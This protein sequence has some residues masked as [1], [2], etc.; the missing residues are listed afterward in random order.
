LEA[1]SHRQG[2]RPVAGTVQRIWEAHRLRAFAE[3]VEDVVGLYM[4]P[5]AHAVVLSIHKKVRGVLYASLK[6][7]Q[8]SRSASGKFLAFGEFVTLS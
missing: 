1:S 7:N 5:P 6:V 2:S 3:K 8:G 4:H